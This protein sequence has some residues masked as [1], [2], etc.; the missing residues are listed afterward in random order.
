A[1]AHGCLVS[2]D[3]NYRRLLWPVGEEPAP[4]ILTAAN[5][6]DIVKFSREELEALFGEGVDFPDGLQP[7]TGRLVV[8]SDGAN[9]LQVY[10]PARMFTLRPP[11]VE[12]KDTTAA[13]DSFVAGL[14]Y[15]LGDQADDSRAFDHWLRQPDKLEEALVFASRCGAY[16]AMHYGAF[17]ALPTLGPLQRLVPETI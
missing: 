3:V 8:V 5:M 14:L 10:S 9:P 4:H 12:A 2:F 1:K 13:G 16:T 15:R 6:A 11:S 7:A 17:E